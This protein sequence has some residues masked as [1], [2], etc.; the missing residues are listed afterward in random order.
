MGVTS[1]RLLTVVLAVILGLAVALIPLII[2]HLN[3]A[4]RGYEELT[5]TTE[6]DHEYEGAGFTSTFLSVSLNLLHAGFIIFI[7]LMVALLVMLYVRR[8]IHL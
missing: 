1:N 8:T 4:G 5:R 6:E 2:L 7:G 3:M